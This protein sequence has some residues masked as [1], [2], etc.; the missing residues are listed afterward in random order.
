MTEL[1]SDGKERAATENSS[2]LLLVLNRF[3][4]PSF[5]LFERTNVGDSWTFVRTLDELESPQRDAH[6][7]LVGDNGLRIFFDSERLGGLGG[8]DLYTATR[9][10]TSSPF[11]TATP[12]SELNSPS[13]DQAIWVA[14]DMSYL[15]FVSDRAGNGK[16]IYESRLQ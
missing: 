5:E 12:V 9:P 8:A 16:E 11:A 4:V 15:L 7:I 14:P 10:D 1:N 13:L 3:V 6:A 2:G